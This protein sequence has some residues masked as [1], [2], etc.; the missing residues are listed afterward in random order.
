MAYKYCI[1]SFYKKTNSHILCLFIIMD[2]ENIICNT[3][4]IER[5]YDNR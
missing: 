5:K 4:N 3:V 1:T 2:N